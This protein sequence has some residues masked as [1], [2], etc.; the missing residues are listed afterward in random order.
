MNT[1]FFCLRCRYSFSSGFRTHC[2][3]C[4]SRDILPFSLSDTLEKKICPRESQHSLSIVPCNDSGAVKEYYT[5]FPFGELL[6]KRI[7]AEHTSHPQV[8]TYLYETD[9]EAPGYSRLKR[10]TYPSGSHVDYSYDHWGRLLTKCEPWVGGGHKVTRITYEEDS[11][12]TEISRRVRE[13]ILDCQDREYFL[14]ETRYL[15]TQTAQGKKEEKKQSAAG[16]SVCHRSLKEWHGENDENPAS[17]GKLKRTCDISGIQHF[18]EYATESANTLS[19]PNVPLWTRTKTLTVKDAPVP[20]QSTRTRE[21]FDAKGNCLHL[22]EYVHDGSEFVLIRSDRFAYNEGGQPVRCLLGNGTEQSTEW[23]PR[24]PV[25]IRNA[26]GT[27]T[28]FEYDSLNRLIQTTENQAGNAEP[29]SQEHLPRITR[30]EYDKEGHLR[31][32]IK[33]QGKKISRTLYTYDSSGRL[34]SETN[35]DSLTTIYSHTPDELATLISHPEGNTSFTRRHERGALLCEGGTGKKN[36]FHLYSVTPAGIREQIRVGRIDGPLETE[37]LTNGFDQVIL[38]RQAAAPGLMKETAYAYN[39]KGQKVEERTCGLAPFRLSYDT[40]GN[41]SGKTQLVPYSEDSGK[42]LPWRVETRVIRYCRDD[43]DPGEPAESEESQQ[44]LM[45]CKEIRAVYNEQGEPV[46]ESKAA[47]ISAL[48]MQEGE[49]QIV[50]LD[51]YCHYSVLDASLDPGTGELTAY[52]YLPGCPDSASKTFRGDCLIRKKERDGRRTDYTH[53]L[54]SK[55]VELTAPEDK[56]QDEPRIRQEH[57]AAGRL[58][59]L[60]QLTTKKN[61]HPHFPEKEIRVRFSYDDVSGVLLHKQFMDMLTSYEYERN[62]QLSRITHASGKEMYF[63]YTPAGE[64]SVIS[65]DDDTPTVLYEYGET[66]RLRRIHDGAGMHDFLLSPENDL[67]A[68]E[69]TQTGTHLQHLRDIL[70]RPSGQ[71]LSRKDEI[72]QSVHLDYDRYN[73]VKSLRENELAACRF[74]YHPGTGSLSGIAYPQGIRKQWLPENK[75]TNCREVKYLFPHTLPPMTFE[76]SLPEKREEP[77]EDYLI[78]LL[79]DPLYPTVL[80]TDTGV[81]QITYNALPL[82]SVFRQED[83]RIELLYDYRGRCVKKSVF[84]ND[85]LV[86]KL[87]YIYAGT[88]LLA[89]FDA[90]S[91]ENG[92]SP[93]LLCSYVWSP[94][95]PGPL[96]MTLWKNGIG[97]TSHYLHDADNNIRG[98]VDGECRLRAAYQYAESGLVSHCDGDLAGINPFRFGSSYYDE[99][100]G[101]YPAR[102]IPAASSGMTGPELPPGAPVPPSFLAHCLLPFVRQE[103]LDKLFSEDRKQNL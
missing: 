17:R 14:T 66:G 81:W 52:S 100:L 51:K 76:T 93:L 95:S 33:I 70:G 24:G 28:E 39:E 84:H 96:S 92:E 98:I 26:S 65:F 7:R 13:F 4:E 74:T 42:F 61:L 34:T 8:W 19:S 78:R 59:M 62:G 31:S 94:V 30:N 47:K 60:H 77:T 5:V 72:I 58:I 43:F 90:T 16:S 99:D 49:Y 69:D 27:V 103:A 101:L 18:C 2:P 71:I 53:R 35:P 9:P 12:D 6:T 91:E 68:E 45:Y 56:K 89:E 20:G 10:K 41:L 25:R 64:L 63:Q 75:K 37:I 73:R 21:T 40:L 85:T 36:R 86:E 102:F 97:T 29:E 23:S 11:P 67:E 46:L 15:V 57:D 3:V 55:G 88:R 1:P 38:L 80:T 32:C 87:C 22:Q 44:P 50:Y 83:R 48:D 82:P 54:G 79:S